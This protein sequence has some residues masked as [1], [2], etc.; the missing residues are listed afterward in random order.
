MFRWTRRERRERAVKVG[1]RKSPAGLLLIFLFS[2]IAA[3]TAAPGRDLSS[4]GARARRE[5]T[6]PWSP[7]PSYHISYLL[8]AL[9]D[10]QRQGIIGRVGEEEMNLIGRWRGMV[11]EQVDDGRLLLLPTA[12]KPFDASYQPGPLTVITNSVL[13]CTK[14][15]EVSALVLEPLK[16]MVTFV[17]SHPGCHLQ[18]ASGYR[19]YATQ[20]VLFANRTNRV[21]KDHPELGG[22]RKKAQEAAARIVAVPGKSQ[23]MTGRAVDFTTAGMGGRLE[24]EFAGTAEGRLLK[25]HAWR[26][27][28]VFP[29]AEGKEEI[30][31]YIYE[32]WHLVYVGKYHAEIIHKHGWV[33]EDYRN[34]MQKEKS[35]L[36]KAEGGELRRYVYDEKTG[37]TK[38]YRV[39]ENEPGRRLFLV[40]K[41]WI[42]RQEEL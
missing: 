4:V 16:E 2:T 20:A 37:T 31:G 19:S 35:I 30:T 11:E 10:D 41:V 23:H 24:E 5:L 3:R 18:V 6:G 15:V 7:P 38:V 8:E 28:F 27:G 25:E 32:P 22:D 21:L 29:Y 9:D 12:E 26:Y 14:R 17:N 1:R 33:L 39:R 34:Y 13:P 40:K 36:F 42:D